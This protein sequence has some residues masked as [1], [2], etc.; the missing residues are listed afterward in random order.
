MF[1][2][3]SIAV[4]DASIR[5]L[6]V[7]DMPAVRMIL[8]NALEEAGYRNVIEA[9]D[10]ELAWQLIR[11]SI[12]ASAGEAIKLVVCDWNMPGMTGID[13]LR[14]VRASAHTRALPFLMVTGE[15]DRAHF[16][17]AGIAGVTD[18]VVKPFSSAMLGQKIK[19]L[20]KS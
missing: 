18:Y 10:G 17:E 3:G 12:G 20:L 5:I 1:D 8:R 13:L 19:A 14:A 11:S 7:D 4:M 2:S 16:E 15:G 6:I 9:E